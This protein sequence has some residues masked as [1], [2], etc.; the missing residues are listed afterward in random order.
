MDDIREV[1]NSFLERKAAGDTYMSLNQ[2]HRDFLI[3]QMKY[4]LSYEALYRHCTHC[5]E[6]DVKTGKPNVES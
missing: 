3:P 6:V 5:L 4:R 2:F 1:L